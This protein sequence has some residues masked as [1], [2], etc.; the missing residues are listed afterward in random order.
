MGLT[1]GGRLDPED[2]SPVVRASR[3]PPKVWA[4][5]TVEGD[6]LVVSLQG[7]RAIWATKRALRVPLTAV[8]SVEHDPGA[9]VHIKTRLRNTRR[10]RTTTFKLGA[11]HGMDG[12]SFW[13]CGLA[14][15]AVVVGTVGTRYR[16]IVAEVA[17]PVSVVRTVRKAA[18]ITPE[19]PA[20]PTVRPIT[21][22]PRL[23]REQQSSPSPRPSPKPKPSAKPDLKPKPDPKPEPDGGDI[24]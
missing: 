14:R 2:T 19:M 20:P 12:W 3:K 21:D 22:S 24:T 15:N 5:L 6:S 23:R 11:Q 10:V 17:D 13:A 16:Y 7:W 9:Y 8:V 18:G 4:S 1:G